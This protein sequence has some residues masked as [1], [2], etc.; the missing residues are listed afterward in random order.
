VVWLQEAKCS[1]P[2]AIAQAFAWAGA[3]HCQAGQYKRALQYF[4]DARPLCQTI[5]TASYTLQTFCLAGIAN[6][7]TYSNR[8]RKAFRAIEKQRQQLHVSLATVWLTKGMAYQ[9]SCKWHKA[10]QC[11]MRAVMYREQSMPNTLDAVACYTAFAATL[12]SFNLVHEV[13]K[14]WQKAL[15]IYQKPLSDERPFLLNAQYKVEKQD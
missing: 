8:P 10:Q 12:E 4:M 11:F 5:G 3:I 1:K 9:R 6:I 15:K 13:Q 7:H 14:Y 2:L